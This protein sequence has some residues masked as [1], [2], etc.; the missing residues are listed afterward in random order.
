LCRI[1]D[2]NCRTSNEKILN[3]VSDLPDESDDRT[4]IVIEL[5]H[6]VMASI[7]IN[8]LFKHARLESSCGVIMFAL[9]K[10]RPKQ[11]NIKEM[12]EYYIEHCQNVRVRITEFRSN[13]AEARAHI[14]E[15]LVIALDNLDD[16][17]RIIRKSTNCE[18]A[19]SN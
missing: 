8:K 7:M 13:K 5:K 10:L 18:E 2:Q 17:V 14:P 4:R 19:K 11:M 12:L 16:F 3:E 6:D 9:D 1:D 15:G